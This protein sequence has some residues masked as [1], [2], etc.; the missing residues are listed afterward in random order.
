MVTIMLAVNVRR[1]RLLTTDSEHYKTLYVRGRRIKV[2][3][4][5]EIPLVRSALDTRDVSE[6]LNA[7]RDSVALAEGVA[8]TQNEL[9]VFETTNL[10]PLLTHS[11]MTIAIVNDETRSCYSTKPTILEVLSEHSIPLFGDLHRALEWIVSKNDNTT[12]LLF[13]Q[14]REELFGPLKEVDD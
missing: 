3:A 11:H 14:A 4:M 9:F 10:L 5:E 6:I 8:S 12:T 7:I 2:F 13:N 1:K